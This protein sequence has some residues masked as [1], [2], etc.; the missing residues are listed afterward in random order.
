MNIELE[1]L[2]KREKKLIKK[3]KK[4]ERRDSVIDFFYKD[5]DFL[6]SYHHGHRI[7]HSIAGAF[8]SILIASSVVIGILLCFLNPWLAIVGLAGIGAGV[9]IH[10]VPIIVENLSLTDIDVE[11]E[12]KDVQLRIEAIEK[13]VSV[14]VLKEQKRREQEIIKELSEKRKLEEKRKSLL[15][16]DEKRRTLKTRAEELAEELE[17]TDKEKAAQIR[18]LLEDSDDTVTT[19]NDCD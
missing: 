16:Q 7:S 1:N 5:R 19:T 9:G 15:A 13:G 17:S 12:L 3:L 10:L 18:K 8:A 2:K 11:Y 4:F 14:E 6:S